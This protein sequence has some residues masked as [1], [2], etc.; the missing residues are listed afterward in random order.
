MF[1]FTVRRV[2]KPHCWR[3]AAARRRAVAHIGPEPSGLGSARARSQH[4]QRL[5]ER[6]QQI[7][8]LGDPAC[9]RGA[10]QIDTLAGI[11]LRLPIERQMVAEISRRHVGQKSGAE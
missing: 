2:G 8:G 9:Q 1:A 5:D 6:L 11:D 7:A 4:A 10:I 3:R